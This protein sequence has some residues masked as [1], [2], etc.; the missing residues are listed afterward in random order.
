MN[1]LIAPA[2]GFGL[3]LCMT[4]GCEEKKP[5]AHAS[6]PRA[7]TTL[8]AAEPDLRTIAAVLEKDKSGKTSEPSPGA[9]PAGHP[10]VPGMTPAKSDSGL[11]AGH[12]PIDS[13]LPAAAPAKEVGLKFTAPATWQ[14][15]P[16]TSSMRKAQYTLPKAAGDPEDGQLIVFYFGS[17][18]GGGIDG[19][20][21]RW[22]GM[23]ST[24]DGSPMP[25]N[26]LKRESITVNGMNVT[27]VDVTGRY[28]DSMGRPDKP[29]PTSQD[30]RMLAAIIE[31]PSGPW[32][33]KAV[34]PVA[35]MA[36]Q[37]AAFQEFV[38]SAHP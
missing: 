23:F 17:G 38:R 3:F 1:R 12:P 14:E 20:I 26:A 21:S 35:T 10:P 2:I 11:P 30:F 6:R 5:P 31:T 37:S 27:L 9:M 36:A 16:V 24:A 8:P 34:G 19:N 7:A 4:A 22:K 18:Q 32:F 13:T 33:F 15:V 28:S 29:G 25:D